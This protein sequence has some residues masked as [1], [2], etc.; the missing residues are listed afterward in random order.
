MSVKEQLEMMEKIYRINRN[1]AG[2]PKSVPMNIERCEQENYLNSF[3]R[4]AI[5]IFKAIDLLNSTP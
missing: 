3:R 1:D 2:H 4:Y 5:T